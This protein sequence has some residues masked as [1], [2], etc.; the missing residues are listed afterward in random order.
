MYQVMSNSELEY[1]NGILTFE[2]ESKIGIILY[3][4][5]KVEPESY[6]YLGE[7]LS[8]KGYTVYI[9]SMAFNFAIFDTQKAEDIIQDANHI[10]EWYISGHSLGGV[11]AAKFASEHLDKVDGLVLLASY[12]SEKDSLKEDSLP[13][14]SIYATNDGLTTVNDIERSKEFLPTGSQF[15]E[16][17]GGNHGGFGMY[18]PQ[19]GDGDADISALN[20]QKQIV[21]LINDWI[22]KTTNET[23]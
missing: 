6:S 17:I 4:G 1:T 22:K 2:G 15:V 8:E 13:V 9:P 5:G 23:K 7:Q 14:L 10:E 20:Q 11:A 3:P 18:G 16:V 21:D 19:K 12:P